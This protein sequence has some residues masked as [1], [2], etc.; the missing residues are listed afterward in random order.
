MLQAL[1]LQIY[2][3]KNEA[4]LNQLQQQCAQFSPQDYLNTLHLLNNA[5]AAADGASSS[6]S[7]ASTAAVGVQPHDTLAEHAP[8]TSDLLSLDTLT[9][10][11]KEAATSSA[12]IATTS[13]TA[14]NSGGGIVASG[15][16][17]RAFSGSG[18][19]ISQH[20]R[21]RL[22]SMI[23]TKHKQRLSSSDSLDSPVESNA[24]AARRS[25]TGGS[26]AATAPSVA[27][28]RSAFLPPAGSSRPHPHASMA[29][30][31]MNAP[32]G[33]EN[34][35]RKVLSEPNLKVCSV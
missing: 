14:A 18:Q 12:S 23:A 27:A 20:T 4:M 1:S 16:N 10:S 6:L 35:L 21:D 34:T 25:T 26:S 13:G 5:A 11:A 15:R 30:G 31:D 24:A 8:S 19:T 28:H 9:S 33:G 7:A 2:Q 22:K 3:R 29:M 17:R 32:L